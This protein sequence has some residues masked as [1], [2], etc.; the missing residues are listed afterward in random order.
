MAI[1]VLE[2]ELSEQIRPIGGVEGYNKL[3]ILV[4]YHVRPVGW[5]RITVHHPVVSAERLRE[6]ITEQPGW[7][8]LP[9][10]LGELIIPRAAVSTPL[11]PISV[12]VCTRERAEQ[13]KCCLQALMALDYPHY[14]IIVVDNAS[15]S[16]DTSRLVA[17]LPV[18]Y[19]REERPGLDWARNRGIAEARHDIVAFTDDDAR[20]DRGWLGAI[21]RAFAEPEVMAVTGLVA[22]AELE[23]GAQI[24]FELIYG[25]MGRGFRRRTIRRKT[26]TDRDLLWAS[27]FG[28]GA[29][30]AF[31]RDLFAAIG[32]F[33]VALDVGTPS[34]GGGDNEMFHRLVARGY[35]LCYEPAALVWH[36]HRRDAASL[37][38]LVYNNGRSFGAYLLTCARNRT[39]SRF[40]ILRFA[41]REWLGWWLLRRLRRAGGLPRRLVAIELIGALLSPLAYRA[42][43]TRARQVAAAASAK[44]TADPTSRSPGAW[45][46]PRSSR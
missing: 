10:V 25:G 12:V 44:A 22:P 11:P 9:Y 45:P 15:R 42:A 19:V 1:K 27:N 21:A 36:T 26:L 34:G 33:D 13:L 17:H 46:S 20:P 29:N 31:R 43:Q 30:M 24:R 7:E 3:Y 41:A 16:D 35:T 18:C 8:L 28:V 14:E 39:V 23:A 4:L 40:S 2:L 32:P 5:T 38:Q 6:A 37:R